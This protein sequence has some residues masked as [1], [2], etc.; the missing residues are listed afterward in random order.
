MRIIF[1][2]LPF[3]ATPRTGPCLQLKYTFCKW[4]SF[5]SV[6]GVN[7][8]FPSWKKSSTDLFVVHF[9]LGNSLSKELC[10]DFGI[11]PMSDF[12]LEGGFGSTL[13]GRRI[14]WKNHTCIVFLA[15]L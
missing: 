9:L 10:M 4:M 3:F 11:I 13:W 15:N 1:N 12:L 14:L 5:I 6:S 8:S 2:F 7:S